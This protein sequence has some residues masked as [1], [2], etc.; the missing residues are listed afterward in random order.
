MKWFLI[1]CTCIFALMAQTQPIS[2]G[3]I[4]GTVTGEDG[5]LIAGAHVGFLLQSSPPR[6][7]KAAQT[8]WNVVSAADGSFSLSSLGGG[9]YKICADVPNSAWLNPCEWD[10]G[11]PSA[12]LT[13]SI[14][15]AAVRM[16]F[17]KGA[18]VPIRIDDANHLL[19]QNE[20]KVPGAHFLIGAGT[21]IF[22][23]HHASIASQDATGRNY[24]LLIPYNYAA[25][26]VVR[27]PFFNLSDAGGVSL[28]SG[29]TIQLKVP[30]GQT[31]ATVR[32]IVTGS[33]H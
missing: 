11:P 13:A 3:V 2:T 5:T 27:S 32:L 30:A 29:T 14:H 1:P 22:S 8:F 16:V 33:G 18:A 26:L 24:Q 20:G 12:N 31:P 28:P 9:A 21:A 15:S 4:A 6:R 10:L 7:R 23:F 19:A 25:T 17:K